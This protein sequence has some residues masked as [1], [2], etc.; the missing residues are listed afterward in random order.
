MRISRQR[1]TALAIA[2]AAGV[3]LTAGCTSTPTG[4]AA[5]DTSSITAATAAATDP[6]AAGLADSGAGETVSPSAAGLN[7]SASGLNPSDASPN[8]SAAGPNP[9]AAAVSSSAAGSNP[10]AAV[11]TTGDSATT[12]PSSATTA[13]G[14][15]GASAADVPAAA[16]SAPSSYAG[17]TSSPAAQVSIPPR[18]TTPVPAPGGGNIKQI[19]PNG[20]RTTQGPVPVA[21][22]AAYGNGITVKLGEIK[23]LKTTPRLPGEIGGPGVAVAVAIRNGSTAPIDL[24]TVTVDLQ[25]AAGV[26]ASPM[27][28]DPAKP[29]SGQLAA[30]ATKTGTYVYSFPPNYRN[31]D[32]LTVSYSAQAPVVLFTGTIS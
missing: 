3:V 16:T 15:A 26:P 14:A 32:R 24:S 12:S 13:S 20:P 6:L 21:G 28:A 31:P 19:M 30:G 1:L 22:T 25:D 18:A 7:P 23:K 10:A 9:S 4:P 29:L 27:S 17:E 8:P 5:A 2:A 11:T